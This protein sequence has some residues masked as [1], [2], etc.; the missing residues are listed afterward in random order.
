MVRVTGSEDRPATDAAEAAVEVA[1]GSA[2]SAG[3]LQKV[4][5]RNCLAHFRSPP[6]VK[7]QLLARTPLQSIRC[8]QI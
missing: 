2:H 6:N 1:A 7:K 3:D 8:I 5:T 4:T